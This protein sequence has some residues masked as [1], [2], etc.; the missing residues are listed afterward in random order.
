MRKSPSTP[1]TPWQVKD[2]SQ[3]LSGYIERLGEVW[4]EAQLAQI[5]LRTG[6]RT[7]YITLRDTSNEQSVQGVCSRNIL[8]QC[9]PRPQEGDQV[10]IHGK[11]EFHQLRGSLQV[12]IHSIRHVGL[13]QLLA[14]IEQL[15][16]VLR[17]EG[18]FDDSRKKP[19][20]FLPQTIG[21]ITGKDSAAQKDVIQVAT[22]RWPAAQFRVIN[23]PVQGSY[24][25][26]SIIQALQTLDADSSIEVIIIA[27]GGGSVEDLLPFSDEGLCRATALC[28]TPVVS[29]IGHE[30]D[31]PLLDEVAD[32]RAA[33]PTD[34]AKRVVPDVVGE[35]DILHT[36][37][38]RL[39]NS[40]YNWLAMET[41][42]ITDITQ[43][44]IFVD[45]S[46]ILLADKQEEVHLLTSQMRTRMEM[47]MEKRTTDIDYLHN[48]VLNLSPL[49]TLARGYSIVTHNG[50]TVQSIQGIAPH[51]DLTIRLT[52]GSVHTHVTHINTDQQ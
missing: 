50:K 31:H 17:N 27:R 21:L 42:I 12:R 47:D 15:R 10:V 8:E 9:Q 48:H 24:A 19:L 14:K 32:L 41:R 44:R 34:A 51:D 29:A 5:T 39:K 25:P 3:A 45:P 37:S 20:P 46:T 13:G 36:A 7:G 30:P 43:R 22:T 23:T 6:A 1:E 4:I 40:L 26:P 38:L 52:D 18:L 16:T 49:S 28:N 11:I 33:T 35:L 2:L